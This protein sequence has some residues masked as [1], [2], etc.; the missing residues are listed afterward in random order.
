MLSTDNE[1]VNVN[2]MS[3][4]RVEGKEMKEFCD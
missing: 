2:G 1:N 3:E 4:T